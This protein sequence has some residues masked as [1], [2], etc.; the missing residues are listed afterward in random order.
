VRARLLER[1]VERGGF[2]P[3]QSGIRSLADDRFTGD[4]EKAVFLEFH[5]HRGLGPARLLGSRFLKRFEHRTYA[6]L[7]LA[8]MSYQRVRAIWDYSLQMIEAAAISPQRFTEVVTGIFDASPVKGARDILPETNDPELLTELGEELAP[9]RLEPAFKALWPAR[10]LLVRDIHWDAYWNRLNSE[11]LS[12]P[13][14]SLSPLLSRMLLAIRDPIKLARRLHEEIEAAPGEPVSVAGLVTSDDVFRTVLFDPTKERF[15]VQRR[16][17]REEDVPWDAVRASAREGR[18]ARA[19]GVLEYLLLAAF[20]FYLLVDCGDQVQPFHRDACR[21]HQR[22]L[23]TKFPWASFA[24]RDELGPDA[25]RFTDIYRPGF[26]E[27]T[28][29]V[30]SD[31]FES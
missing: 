26:V 7:R 12:L 25:N 20:G 18:G 15:F 4:G 1:I 3:E 9:Y 6:S 23:G 29:D 5:L 28:V 21:I 2:D 16:D 30:L 31:F 11:F 17:G 8:A 10:A 19:S 24:V 14:D 27:L 13:V 22:Q